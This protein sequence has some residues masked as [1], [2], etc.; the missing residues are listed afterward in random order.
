MQYIVSGVITGDINSKTIAIHNEVVKCDQN[1]CD[2]MFRMCIAQK[3][4][5]K[6]NRTEIM[7][8]HV[9][10]TNNQHFWHDNVHDVQLNTSSR[11]IKS[12]KLGENR[13][14]KIF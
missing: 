7:T 13:L 4:A 6:K 5:N 9:T 12:F 3:Q 8:F 14:E 11:S 2:E 1:E 10:A